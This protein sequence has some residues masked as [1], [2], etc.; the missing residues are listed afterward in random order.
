[1]P[2]F[3]EKKLKSEYPGDKSAPFAIMNKLGLMH[4]S[5]ETAK[6]AAAEDKHA[7]DVAHRALGHS[8]PPDPDRR[9]YTYEP[10]KEMDKASSRRERTRKASQEY[11][12]VTKGKPLPQS[13]PKSKGW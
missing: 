8:S 6:G 1:M 11:D 10:I 12:I 2:E 7:S 4:G 13:A 3:L 5:K 9:D